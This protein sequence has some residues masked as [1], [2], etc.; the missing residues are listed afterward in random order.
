MQMARQLL[1]DYLAALEQQDIDAIES[2]C[3][4]GCLLEIPFLE[5]RRLVGGREIGKAH[6]EIFANLEQIEIALTGI[7]ADNG[8]A[9]GEGRLRVLRRDGDSYDLHLAVAAETGSG[10]YR[11]ISLYCDTRNIRRWSDKRIL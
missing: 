11:R 10:D 1:E 3:T 9:I 4:P 6:R 8:H 7:A 2:L 5:P